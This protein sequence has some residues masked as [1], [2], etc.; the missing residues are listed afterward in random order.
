MI[1]INLP[2]LSRL[3]T[4][5]LKNFCI[6]YYFQMDASET[7]WLKRNGNFCGNVLL[8]SKCYKYFIYCKI[9]T[10]GLTPKKQLE[11]TPWQTSLQAHLH[12]IFF[13][14]PYHFLGYRYYQGI[15]FWASYSS[16]LYSSLHTSIFLDHFSAFLGS[17]LMHLSLGKV[18]D[19]PPLF[20]FFQLL[21]L[22]PLQLE[23]T[24]FFCTKRADLLSLKS[25]GP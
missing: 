15:S 22:L 24:H 23:S 11:T 3:H 14:H 16:I 13:H 18:S 19:N 5:D 1:F 17:K 10:V 7:Y 25:G 8:K 2:V 4:Y 20:I 12:E 21:V 9:S 6:S